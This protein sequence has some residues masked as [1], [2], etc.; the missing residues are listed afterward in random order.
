MRNPDGKKD[1]KD[2]QNAILLRLGPTTWCRLWRHN[3]GKARPLS[4]PETVIQYGRPGQSDIMGI[5]TCASGAG[6]FL[7]IECKSEDG[8]VSDEQFSWLSM[9]TSFGGLALV[10]QFKEPTQAS[11]DAEVERL[12]GVIIGWSQER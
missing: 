12:V 1:E 11:I 6:C 5:V 9:V 10:S 7:S 4:N 3:V 2:L 8:E